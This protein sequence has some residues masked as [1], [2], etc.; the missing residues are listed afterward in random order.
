MFPSETVQTAEL[1]VTL[2]IRPLHP[3][4]CAGPYSRAGNLP[5]FDLPV[6]LVFS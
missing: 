2:L 5:G 1:A 4:D 6:G 3:G